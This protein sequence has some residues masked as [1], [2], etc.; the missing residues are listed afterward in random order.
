MRRDAGAAERGGF[1]N[2][3]TL[4]GTG[5]SNPS[6]SA[7]FLVLPVKWFRCRVFKYEGGLDGPSFVL[8]LL[9]V[10]EELKEDRHTEPLCARFAASIRRGTNLPGSVT[11]KD[12]KEPES[13]LPRLAGRVEERPNH[14]VPPVGGLPAS[15]NRQKEVVTLRRTPPP[16]V[17][18]RVKRQRAVDPAIR[19]RGGIKGKD[20]MV[21]VAVGLGFR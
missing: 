8:R 7:I 6:L 18:K 4:A 16:D 1:E 15:K 20:V 5:G 2:R 13:R 9:R 19:E 10:L 3:C 17:E 14:E 11:E 21:R 12:R